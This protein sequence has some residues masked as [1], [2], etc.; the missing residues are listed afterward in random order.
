MPKVSIIIVNWN[1]LQH[2]PACLSSVTSQSY[3]YYEVIMV[4]NGSTD[5]SVEYVERAFPQVRV[6]RHR[7]NLGFAAGNNAAIRATAGEYVATLNNDAQA[8]PHWL[9]ELVSAVEGRP[10]VGMAAS[11]MLLA[12]WPEIID[13]AGIAVDWAGVA[14][15]RRHGEQ[16]DEAAIAPLDVFGPCAGA[17]LYRR[18]MLEDV[19]SFDE[20]YFA[21]YEDVDLAWRAQLRSWRCLYVPTA[22]VYHVHSATG[23]EGWPWKNYLLGRNKLW[24]I[25]KNCPTGLLVLLLPLI[26]LFDA[27]AVAYHLAVR[28][29][30]SPLLGRLAGLGR[31]PIVWRKRRAIQGGRRLSSLALLGLMSPPP[32][33]WHMIRRQRERETL[34]ARP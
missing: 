33:P 30:L 8:D 12:A 21:Y 5:G 23:G 14:W 31:L 24:T 17:A 28:R 10:E 7:E 19:G 6:I 27:G 4:D 34:L 22:T 20:D 13:S 25:G 9:A 18:A 16:G 11:R 15:N 1:G 2:L 26:L 29:D 3:P 32:H